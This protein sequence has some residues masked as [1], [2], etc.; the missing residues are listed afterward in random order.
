MT[1]DYVSY[2]TMGAMN[3]AQVYMTPEIHI[4]RNNKK[5][6]KS[7]KEQFDNQIKKIIQDIITLKRPSRGKVKII[8]KCQQALF[9]MR[10]NDDGER[11]LFDYKYDLGSDK[12][13]VINVKL[14]VLAV[15]NKK[16]IK[17]ILEISAEHKVHASSLDNL[18]PIWAETPSEEIELSEI[19]S[20][21]DLD[22]LRNKARKQF[23][24]TVGHEQVDEWNTENYWRRIEHATIFD[25]RLPNFKNPKE[26]SSEDSIPEILKLQKEQDKILENN[27]PQLLLEGVAGTG[28][29]TMLLYRFVGNVKA[30][31]DQ[32]IVSPDGLSSKFLFVTHNIRLQNEVKRYLRY[33][34]DEELTKE[35]E[36][37]ILS[38]E[39][40]MNRITG[41]RISLDKPI[42][43]EKG[44][45]IYVKK[46]Q[47]ENE[48][49]KTS[50]PLEIMSIQK[51]VNGIITSFNCY[52]DKLLQPGNMISLKLDTKDE[53]TDDKEE[54]V[55]KIKS[56]VI[57]GGFVN[58]RRLT[59]DRFRR[60]LS[61]REIDTDMFWEEYRGVLRGYNL[62][63][64]H[65]IVEKQVYLDEIG[66]RRGRLVPA[67]RD[68]F[69]DIADKF[70]R[71]LERDENLNPM[72]GG[73]DD[74]DLCKLAL[75]MI[76]EN[77]EKNTI[78]FLYIDEVQDLTIAEIEIFLRRL[79]LNGLKR[80]SMAGDLSQSVQPS[81][82][83]WQALRDQIY[84]TLSIR[85]TDEERLDQN[86]RSTPFLVQSAN[87]V[88]EMIG[89]YEQETPKA[90]QRPL[91]GENYGERL[92]RFSGTED[93]LI[94][95]LN[96]EGL[97]NSGCVLLVR[98]ESEKTRLSSKLNAK[99]RSFVETIVKFKG[100]EKRNV[101]LWDIASGSERI[102]DLLHHA[103]RGPEALTKL[104][105]K[106]TAVIELK[107]VF[108]ALTRARFLCGV[109]TPNNN[110]D[111]NQQYFDFRFNG[112]D[113]FEVSSN[114]KIGLFATK[115]GS[116]VMERFAQEYI[117]GRQFGMASG[118]YRN[119][120]GKM[121]ESDYYNGKFHIEE[122]NYVEAINALIL[123]ID[124]GGAFVEQCAELIAE[125]CELAFQLIKDKEQ[126]NL[127]KS[128]VI[129]YAAKYIDNSLRFRFQAET[130]EAK[131]NFENAAQVYINANLT[132]EFNRVIQRIESPLKKAQLYI[133]IGNYDRAEKLVRD[134]LSENE[135]KKALLLSLG[136]QSLAD[137]FGKSEIV[138]LE[139]RFVKDFEWAI[140]LIK[141]SELKEFRNSVQDMKDD[142]ILNKPSTNSPQ[143][144]GQQLEIYYRRRRYD[145]LKEK[146]SS[147][148]SSKNHKITNL[149]ETYRLKIL[150]HEGTL[151]ELLEEIL[152]DDI[153]LDNLLNKSLPRLRDIIKQKPMEI[154]NT[155]R[156]ME[157][158]IRI[159]LEDVTDTFGQHLVAITILERYERAFLEKN[160]SMFDALRH[161][162]LSFYIHKNRIIKQPIV[163]GCASLIATHIFDCDHP[164]A[165]KGLEPHHTFIA[166]IQQCIH[167]RKNTPKVEDLSFLISNYLTG[168]HMKK[169]PMVSTLIACDYKKLLHGIKPKGVEH[170]LFLCV[171]T[172]NLVSDDWQFDR[173]LDFFHGKLSY[174]NVK[175]C[176]H[177]F[178]NILP[179][180]MKKELINYKGKQLD[181][182][183]ESNLGK[184]S[185][186]AKKELKWFVSEL[187]M[188]NENLVKVWSSVFTGDSE[189]VDLVLK[190][191]D[192]FVTDNLDDLE[193]L[194]VEETTTPIEDVNDTQNL[195]TLL[196]EESKPV[197]ME[198]IQVFEPFE[199]SDDF[200]ETIKNLDGNEKGA[201]TAG[202]IENILQLEIKDLSSKDKSDQLC[203]AF[204]SCLVIDWPDWLKFAVM[205]VIK[206]K[207]A[208]FD[209]STNT[210]Y[211]ILSPRQ[212]SD[213]V[214][215]KNNGQKKQNI[216]ADKQYY[217]S[218]QRIIL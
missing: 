18:Y 19:S 11:I 211:T 44:D 170:I 57:N 199:F 36:K 119:M 89:E 111:L 27:N 107:H 80:L 56:A 78:E 214:Q 109:L 7:T 164:Y 202:Y 143:I 75:S 98:G 88:L 26:F 104:A 3:K 213:Y 21:K 39:E 204:E 156:H 9:Y 122:G 159:L 87:S 165:S 121:H 158:P 79:D 51:D 136:K 210:K 112:Q 17:E 1:R 42:I 8:A 125:Y 10:L 209:Q 50:Q 131:G 65:R 134:Y 37:C 188:P 129:G 40:A 150:N 197:E 85:V 169:Q 127:M 63:G 49:L 86:F 190:V 52:P 191:V 189:K 126:L 161:D 15:S 33:F 60:I 176:Y 120:I 157:Y 61:G 184:L 205:N 175:D 208:I 72:N 194:S 66:R 154:Y 48:E 207:G 152:G 62:H 81:A 163:K 168:K 146:L 47:V 187:I 70:E 77:T 172:S 74:L 16:N 91:D 4:W 90:L 58:K 141:K 203:S 140:M 114:E 117:Q 101:L 34:F 192:D 95:L 160:Q 133:M 108:V 106:T 64:D 22:K 137:I 130:E 124:A 12:K 116:E 167:W 138:E 73:W 23:I 53:T 153:D 96:Q 55:F 93:E 216:I 177:T 32:K 171:G 83:T 206:D 195:E 180:D 45:H 200:E 97:P 118:T 110:N 82:F 147:I 155:I 5:T 142:E 185:K 132:S 41:T 182:F 196:D 105:N 186:Q 162:L 6:Q 193:D 94:Q 181:G 217:S 135:P 29:T 218:W 69:Y 149:H 13:S 102:L 43:L 174:Y 25:F 212:E 113:Y 28:K 24:N 35:V 14:Y 38:V 67:E 201:K 99:S 145:A 68:E 30:M 183:L 59:R 151:T 54:E 31:L 71:D 84:N 46:K 173:I 76:A 103:K 92:L 2:K 123:A 178:N 128:K 166:N 179:S 139:D 215:F 148:K 115:V 100:L 20:V 144:L 198:T